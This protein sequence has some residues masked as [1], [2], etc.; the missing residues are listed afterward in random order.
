M[1]LLVLAPLLPTLSAPDALAPFV[2]GPILLLLAILIALLFAGSAAGHILGLRAETPEAHRTVDNLVA[3]V[4][5]WWA[6]IAVLTF[7]FSLGRAGVIGLFMLLSFLALREL[8]T[9]APSRRSDHASYVW[10]FFLA[11]PAQFLLLWIGWY[12]LFTIFIPVYA[13]FALSVRIAL[14][15]DPKGYLQR[16]ASLQYGLMIGVYCVSH[17]PALLM[18]EIDGYEGQQFKLIAFLI[19]VTQ[20]SDILQY[21]WGTLLGERKIAPSLSPSKTVEGFIGGVCS[22]TLLGGALFW[23]T[24]FSPLAAT[25]LSLVITLAGFCGGLVMSAIKRDAGVK[26]YGN[27]LAGHG[28]VMDRLDSL[29]FAAPLFFHL[30]RWLYSTV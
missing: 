17:A 16:A 23:L 15:G 20:L 18:L 26:D 29:A 6:M 27:L 5:A 9:L 22:A 13:F 3:R 28:G 21:I 7:A 4:N 10:A 19:A 24:P 11:V 1:I 8:L 2:D 30:V 14:S 12:G 25:A